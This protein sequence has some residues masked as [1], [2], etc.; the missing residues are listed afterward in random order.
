[1]STRSY[2]GTVVVRGELAPYRVRYSRRARSPS[3]RID[4]RRGLEVVLPEGAPAENVANLLQEQATWLDRHADDVHRAGRVVRMQTGTGL[5]MRGDWATLEVV[6]G[7]R[8]R[9]LYADAT[10]RVVAPSPSDE[11][12]IHDQLERWYRTQARAV[13]PARV[14][15]LRR[16]GDGAIK[17]VTIRDQ[18]TCWASCSGQGTLSFNWRLVMAPPDVLDAVVTHELV[19]LR[20]ADHSSRFWVALNER[21]PRSDACRRWLDAN[22]YRLGF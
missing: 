17:R 14:E 6:R 19:H 21:Y 12:A 8:P 3:L 5:P 22:A 7:E 10:I 9:I 16:P 15:A 18:A 11:R 1:M 20:I 13:V 4:A 2:D